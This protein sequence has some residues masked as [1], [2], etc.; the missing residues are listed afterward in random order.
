MPDRTH[1]FILSP[2]RSRSTW[3]RRLL[4]SHPDVRWRRTC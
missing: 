1:Y 3:F 4:D 2:Q